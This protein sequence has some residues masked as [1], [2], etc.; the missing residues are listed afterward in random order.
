[1]IIHIG[2]DSEDDYDDGHSWLPFE[3]SG[4][5]GETAERAEV[6]IARITTPDEEHNMRLTMITL[7]QS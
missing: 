1:M 7:N 6:Q 3:Q 5:G 2:D 4:F